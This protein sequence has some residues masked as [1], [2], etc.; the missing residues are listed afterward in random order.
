MSWKAGIPG[1]VR[2]LAQQEPEKCA[3]ITENDIE[4]LWKLIED[5]PGLPANPIDKWKAGNGGD[6]AKQAILKQ[7][8]NDLFRAEMATALRTDAQREKSG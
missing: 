2:I 6:D 1:V 5:S 8:D 4:E 3:L 7:L